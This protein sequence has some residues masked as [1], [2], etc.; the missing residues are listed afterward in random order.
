MIIDPESYYDYLTL[1]RN[2]SILWTINGPLSG[3]LVAG[4][5]MG[6]FT[7]IDFMSKDSPFPYHATEIIEIG[8]YHDP[9]NIYHSPTSHILIDFSSKIPQYASKLE[10]SLGNYIIAT[11][12]DP[13]DYLKY[14]P[15]DNNFAWWITNYAES[16]RQLNKQTGELV[17]YNRYTVCRFSDQDFIRGFIT[18]CDSY[19]IDFRNVSLGKPFTYNTTM[20]KR[21]YHDIPGYDTTHFTLTPRIPAPI[22]PYYIEDYETGPFGRDFN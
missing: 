12:A 19:N 9:T 17:A 21:I 10:K 13:S 1:H 11:R 4:L 16:Y 5:S 18:I 15:D 3:N 6:I 22:G 2:G 14:N 8:T 20:R 7:M